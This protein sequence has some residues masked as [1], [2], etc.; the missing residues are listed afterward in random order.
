MKMYGEVEIILH[1]FSNL[2]LQLY[3]LATLPSPPLPRK[4]HWFLLDRKLGGPQSWSGHSDK[5]K[6]SIQ[7]Q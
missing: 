7:S 1:A 5:E 4:S 6:K 3:T 2:A